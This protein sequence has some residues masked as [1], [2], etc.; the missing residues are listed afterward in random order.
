MYYCKTRYYVP[1]WCRWLNADDV[2][3]L[4][5]SSVNGLN[6]YAYCGNDPV[7]YYDPSGHFPI[8]AIFLGLTALVGMVL[9]IGGVASDNNTMTAI[10]LTMV[11]IP[12]LI[13]GGI[14]VAAGI[15]GATYLGI[16]GGGTVIAGIGTGLFASAEY[17]EAITGNNWM[18]DA[19]MSEEWYNG[20]LI[21]T[22]AL[23]TLGTISCGVLGSIGNMSTPNQM[24]NS[25]RNHPNRWNAVKQKIEE[26]VGRKYAGGTSTYTNYVNR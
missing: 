2:S 9:T 18:I 12:A 14:A 23:A 21:T 17:H 25:W 26:A 4:D 13:S 24:M 7:N 1:E 10:G 20:L 6:L 16:I 3:Y 19:G 15:G 5:P 22:A 8:I 11:A